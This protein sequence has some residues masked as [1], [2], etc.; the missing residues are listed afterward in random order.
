V[1]GLDQP[2]DP[3]GQAEREA[4]QMTAHCDALPEDMASGMVEAQR[5]RDA[6]LARAI[7]AAMAEGGGPVVVITGNGHAR[8][9][10]GVPRMLGRALPGA[11]VVSIGQFETAAPEDPPFDYWIVTATVPRDDPCAAF[12]E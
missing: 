1:F 9:D 12:A 7:V 11:S 8:V 4:G 3:V 2:L 5:L 10:W 6:A